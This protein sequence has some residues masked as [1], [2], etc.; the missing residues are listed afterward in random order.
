MFVFMDN[1]TTV[2]YKEITEFLTSLAF[3]YCKFNLLMTSIVQVHK[4]RT[5][6]DHYLAILKI[7]DK[8]GH[9]YVVGFYLHFLLPLISW[10]VCPQALVNDDK[11]PNSYIKTFW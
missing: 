10:L 2:I 4:S 7:F 9:F 8:Y 6:L 3:D 5:H 1:E 11:R